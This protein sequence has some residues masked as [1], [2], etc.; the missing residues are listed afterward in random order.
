MV[1][2]ADL[3]AHQQEV[4]EL[5]EESFRLPSWDLSERQV[6]D[7]ELLL[8]GGFAPLEGFMGKAD[9]ER[10]CKEMR[11]NNGALWPIPV[12]L[13]VTEELASSISEGSRVALRHPEG[14]VLAVLTVTDVWKPDLAEEARQVYGTTEESHPGVFNLFHRT[15]P[16]YV[17]GPLEGIE[18][19]CHHT[20]NDLRHTPAELRSLFKKRGWER[21]VA[22]HTQEPLHRVQVE[23]TRRAAAEARAGLLVHPVVGETGP[24]DLDYFARVNCYR[25]V[26]KYYPERTTVFSLLALAARMAG[27]RE[28]LW[29]AI[30]RRNYGC[31]HFVVTPDHGSPAGGDRDKSFY[32]SAA[33][34]ELVSA[35]QEELGIQVLALEEMVYVEDVGRYIPRSQVPDGGKTL[36][37]SNNELHKRLREGLE[38]PAWF[39]YPEVTAQLRRSRPPRVRQ[40]FTIF[41]TGLPAAGK[42]TTAKV[43]MTK[44]TEIGTRPV[45]LLDGDI[46]RKN[47]SSELGFSK[48]DRDLNVQRIG[49][50]AS[51]ITKNRGVAICAPIAPYRAARQQVR[52]TVSQHGGFIEVYMAT[53]LEVCEARD[54]KG[55]YAKAR[56]GLLK[57][58]TGIDDP[59]EPPEDADV[60]LD[61]SNM[62]P[63]EAASRIL[64]HL[65][66]E[67]FM[68]EA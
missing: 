25:A 55:L 62:S 37:L 29:H 20:F 19:P 17:G 60:V 16:V 15:N 63:E 31:S 12:V 65:E 66:G 36:C 46:V 53:P 47:L 10:V 7:I 22:F 54:R 41:F 57:N 49:F 42:S 48:H 45:T 2:P 43:L 52:E 3:I 9:Y 50:V 68:V 5:R 40:G 67:G 38:V 35:S 26:L 34:Q 13:D 39:S 23:Q 30:I 11:L 58:V 59:Y 6:L 21:V 44:L 18:L 64:S 8:N 24:G 27:P 14:V 4:D 32:P 56:A 33:A 51:E 61:A 28:A 1:R